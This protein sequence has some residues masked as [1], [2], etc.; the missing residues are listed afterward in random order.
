MGRTKT[1]NRHGRKP[2]LPL[3]QLVILGKC[4]SLVPQMT[5]APVVLCRL[6]SR[7]AGWL[8]LLLLLRRVGRANARSR[9]PRVAALLPRASG[10]TGF[11]LSPRFPH[12]PT[13]PH[14]AIST[15]ASPLRAASVL[16]V[17]SWHVAEQ[18]QCFSLNILV[19]GRR[20]S[21]G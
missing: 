15:V 19:A 21:L 13:P 17:K 8:L 11:F 5:P 1:S 2:K 9:C 6:E 20:R 16:L 7:R 14:S 4:A 12:F 10:T 3:Q 18:G